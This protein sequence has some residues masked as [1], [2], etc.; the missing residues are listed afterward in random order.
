MFHWLHQNGALI[1]WL[2]GLSLLMFFGSLVLVTI[3]IVRMPADY[4]AH[5]K[6]PPDSWRGHHPLIRFAVLVIKNV[7]GVVLVVVGAILSLPGVPGQ[8]LL[9]ILIG[10]SLLNFPGKRALE[11]RLVSIRPVL[12]AIN[13]IRAKN[14][15]PPL[16]I[17]EGT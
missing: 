4:F 8:G 2:T 3:L 11:L 15:R 13:W 1:A 7:L 14:H 10:L 9:T 6:P 12:K 17:D 16:E 5:R